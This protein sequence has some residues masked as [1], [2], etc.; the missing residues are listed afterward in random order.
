[1]T[2]ICIKNGIIAADGGMFCQHAIDAINVKKITRAA[3]G[4]L[5]ACAGPA[6]V[7]EYFRRQLFENSNVGDRRIGGRL[8]SGFKEL[9]GDEGFQAIWLEPTGEIRRMRENG[10]VSGHG[11]TTA[12]VGSSEDFAMG[13]M[14]AG[15]SAEEAV[16]LCIE[17]TVYAAGE[18]QVEHLGPVDPVGREDE[19]SG[20]LFEDGE[21]DD[22]FGFD[23]RIYRAS[24]STAPEIDVN[25]WKDKQ[26]LK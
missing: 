24:S 11:E 17:F 20:V 21:A 6:S 7:C 8:V 1:V 3:D 16:R 9:L 14:R 23:T 2:I 22:D 10:L 26:G 5:G 15:A 25:A 4:A 12:A 13:A 18:V 19:G